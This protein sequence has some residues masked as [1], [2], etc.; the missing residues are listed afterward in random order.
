MMVFEIVHAVRH[1]RLPAVEWF[2]PQDPLATTDAH[3]AADVCRQRAHPQFRTERRGTQ[4]RM[5]EVEVVRAL[6]Y[7]IGE[8][9]CQRETEPA[10]RAV[11]RNEIDSC[12]LLPPHRRRA[13]KPAWAGAARVPQCCDRRPCRTTPAGLQLRPPPVCHPRDPGGTFSSSR[14]DRQF[15]HLRAFDR[16]R[17]PSPGGSA[18]CRREGGAPGRDD[19]PAR[20]WLLGERGLQVELS[21][22]RPIPRICERELRSRAACARSERARHLRAV[23]EVAAAEAPHSSPL[24]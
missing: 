2:L 4:L 23:G 10:R 5:R 15:D 11:R 7:M 13:R 16:E 22:I 9:V 17:P 24:R 20:E 3:G 18:R 1:V 19:R 21:R 8:L 12:K 14:S 6:G